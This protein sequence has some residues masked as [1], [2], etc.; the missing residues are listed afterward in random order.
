MVHT[1][2]REPL[3]PVRLSGRT[4]YKRVGREGIP[5][6]YIPGIYTRIYQDIPA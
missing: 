3:L 1:S 6:V 2:G 4:T 5:W